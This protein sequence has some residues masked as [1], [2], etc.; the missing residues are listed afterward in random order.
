MCS[1][2]WR[3]V[4]RRFPVPCPPANGVAPKEPMFG[5]ITFAT[6]TALNAGAVR[7]RRYVGVDAHR[8]IW[9]FLTAILAVIARSCRYRANARPADPGVAMRGSQPGWPEVSRIGR[10]LEAAASHEE[11]HR[12]PLSR[13]NY[14][15]LAHS[16]GGSEGVIRVKHRLN[17]SNVA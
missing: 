14:Y 12:F 4:T 17:P 8:Q 1:V 10:R 6:A 9:L 13:E 16:L 2:C 11:V 7:S 3:V 15:E 5:S